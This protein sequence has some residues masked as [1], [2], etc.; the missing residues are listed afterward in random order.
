MAFFEGEIQ[1]RAVRFL[2]EYFLECSPGHLCFSV[3]E[4]FHDETWQYSQ[5]KVGSCCVGSLM[6]DGKVRLGRALCLVK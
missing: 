3:S 5:L 6:R 1:S 4:G 2:C